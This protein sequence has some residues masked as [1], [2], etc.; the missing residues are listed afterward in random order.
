VDDL[1]ESVRCLADTEGSSVKA[2]VC[3]E[4]VPTVITTKRQGDINK[5]AK[6]QGA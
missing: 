4:K 6:L 5:P 3:V 1:R 2:E